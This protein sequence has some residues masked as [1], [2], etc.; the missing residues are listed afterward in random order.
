MEKSNC[1]NVEPKTADIPDFQVIRKKVCEILDE[2]KSENIA[3]INL[4]P[5]F[6][7]DFWFITASALSSSHLK[8]L[9]MD[10][11]AQL[12]DLGVYS[13]GKPN[14]MEYSSGWVVLDYGEL[15]VHI[16][17]REKRDYYDLEN[18]WEKA[19]IKKYPAESI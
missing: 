10:I 4:K 5:Q 6:G 17:L 15:L 18:L 9:S 7:Y 16:L 11:I 13:S 12:R 14:E 2:N 1:N 19:V 3:L 8:K